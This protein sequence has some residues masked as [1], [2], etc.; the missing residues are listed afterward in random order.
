MKLNLATILATTMAVTVTAAPALEAL[1]ITTRGKS[2]W[3][4]WCPE[5]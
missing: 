3:N 5:V 1:K 2:R 4:L